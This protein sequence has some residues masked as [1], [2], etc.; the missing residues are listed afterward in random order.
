MVG[1]NVDTG[2]VTI[3]NTTINLS[4]Y[5]YDSVSQKIWGFDLV[6][7]LAGMYWMQLVTFDLV[8]ESIDVVQN[9]T[10]MYDEA[11]GVAI[12]STKQQVAAFLFQ[13]DNPFIAA[14]SWFDMD[15]G[16]M[17]KF[18]NV[19]GSSNWGFNYMVFLPS[20]N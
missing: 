19:T 5:N 1:C 3:V 16:K 7:N 14:L 12:D 10:M 13:E 4:S 17:V 9:L 11:F 6:R 20:Q 15:T 18:V 8:S 2:I